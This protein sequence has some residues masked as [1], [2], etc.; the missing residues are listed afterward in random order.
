MGIKTV[1]FFEVGDDYSEDGRGRFKT[2]GRFWDRKV[3]DA[4]AIKRGNFGKDAQVHPVA[5]PI[6]DSIADMDAYHD[7]EKRQQALNKLTD[8]D[9]R[10]L[11]LI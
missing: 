4:Y 8:E 7:E 11:G 10:V 5:L 6:A 9:K 3:A 2:I 1:E